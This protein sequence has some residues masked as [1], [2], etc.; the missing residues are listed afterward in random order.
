MSNET[1]LTRRGLF[2]KL[3]IMFNGLVATAL[4]VP[5]VQFLLSSITRGREDA[6]T[7][8]YPGSRS[9]RSVNFRKARRGSPPSAIHT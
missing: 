9:G 4:A 1:M 5:I 7:P 2:M 3:G 8:I 6:G